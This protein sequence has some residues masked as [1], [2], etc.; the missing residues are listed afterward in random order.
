MSENGADFLFLGIDLGGSGIAA[1][2]CALGYDVAKGV[3]L[4]LVVPLGEIH[5]GAESIPTAIELYTYLAEG[6]FTEFVCRDK[7]ALGRHKPQTCEE[8]YGKND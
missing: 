3:V 1:Y 7:F 4:V 5:K 6:I 8:D 2:R